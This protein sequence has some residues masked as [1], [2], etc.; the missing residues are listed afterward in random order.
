MNRL[1]PV[2]VVLLLENVVL[3]QPAQMNAEITK[4]TRVA[5]VPDH[6]LRMYDSCQFCECMSETCCDCAICQNALLPEKRLPIESCACLVCTRLRLLLRSHCE[7]Y[8]L[9]ATRLISLMLMRCRTFFCSASS[10]A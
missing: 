1:C 3:A 2:N 4:L 10:Q 6:H 8:C 7:L 5:S 9:H